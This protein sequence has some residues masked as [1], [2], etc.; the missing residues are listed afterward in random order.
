M[1]NR[2]LL[3]LQQYYYSETG[4]AHEGTFLRAEPT[5][6]ASGERCTHVT[7][8]SERNTERSYENVVNGWLPVAMLTS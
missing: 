1:S 4:T 7:C 3:T 6:T 2:Q 8:E 5:W